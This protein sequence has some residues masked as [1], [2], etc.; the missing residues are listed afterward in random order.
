M[1]QK[2][3]KAKRI[4]ENKRSAFKVVTVKDFCM[5]LSKTWLY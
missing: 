2:R 1:W 3:G 5:K 4:N